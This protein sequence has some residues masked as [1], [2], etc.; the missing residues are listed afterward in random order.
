MM[1]RILMRHAGKAAVGFAIAGATLYMVMVRGTLAHLEMLSG[2]APLDMR[3]LGYSPAQ[4]VDLFEKLG[5]QGRFYYL[6]RQIPLDMMYPALLGL[7]LSCAICWLGRGLAN[8]KLVR[9]GI[10]VSFVAA[11]FD[12]CEN[13]GIVLLLLNWPSVSD[14]LVFVTSGAS[15]AKAG[16][17]TS[18]V[19]LLGLLAVL[20]VKLPRGFMKS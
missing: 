7:T 10:A 13:I 18:A 2:M 17:T 20:C 1:T 14:L 11:A 16:F 6:T 8:R 12:Y 19:F 9:M 15:V 4:V 5:E 3:P